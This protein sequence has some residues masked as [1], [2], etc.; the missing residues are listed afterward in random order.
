MD[1]NLIGL[2]SLH[3]EENL[4]TDT[5]RRRPCED[6]GTSGEERGA[7]AEAKIRVMLPQAKECPGL[8]EA[9]RGEARV[10]LKFLGKTQL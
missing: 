6:R 9:G 3:E 2:V 1:P 10:S 5:Q 7:N 8:S 4:D